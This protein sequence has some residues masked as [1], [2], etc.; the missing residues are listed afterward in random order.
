VEIPAPAGDVLVKVGDTIDDRH[1]ATSSISL[2]K[3]S[4]I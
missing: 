2:G 3:T 1:R 4:S